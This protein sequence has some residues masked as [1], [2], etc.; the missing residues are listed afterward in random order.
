M[1]TTN[2]TACDR[3]VAR[4][5]EQIGEHWKGSDEVLFRAAWNEGAAERDRHARAE[6]ELA[7]SVTRRH[8]KRAWNAEWI[9][10]RIGLYVD[11]YGEAL[12]PTAAD[13]YG[14]GVRAVKGA[15]KSRLLGLTVSAQSYERVLAALSRIP[16][17]DLEAWLAEPPVTNPE[18]YEDL[19]RAELYRREKEA[20]EISE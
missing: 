14:D 18:A 2:E 12:V 15:I 6:R 10:S 11:E 1:A 4:Y 5:R 20:H 9:L 16:E 19:A 13:T 3:A 8:E 17:Q 7:G